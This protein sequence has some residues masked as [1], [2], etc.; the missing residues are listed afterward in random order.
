MI[1]HQRAIPAV[2]K[3]GILGGGGA[4]FECRRAADRR[5]SVAGDI[6]VQGDITETPE[7]NFLCFLVALSNQ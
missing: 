2:G 5:A 6:A 3:G 7:P 4:E 1:E